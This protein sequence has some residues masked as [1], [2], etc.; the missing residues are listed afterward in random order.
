[1]KK[2][3]LY[4]LILLLLPFG[5]CKKWLTIEPKTETTQDKLF[6]SSQGYTDALT[7]IY[8]SMRT[9]YSP[10]SFMVSS[11][12]EFMSN[13]WY[14]VPDDFSVS[15][16]LAQ[17]NY[18][19]SSAESALGA[20]F[21]AQYNT[22]ANVN[23]LLTSLSTENVLESRVKKLVEGEALALRAFISFDLIR[24][25]GPMPQNP[26]ARLYL[27]YVKE[28][29]KN[30]YPYDNYQSYM[31]KLSA[32]LDKAEMLLQQVDPI[33]R[34]S[35]SALN[36]TYASIPEYTDLFWYMRQNK[37]NYYA[38]LGLQAR[39][40]LWMGDKA[41]AMRY[42]KMV[43]DANASGM[44][45]FT[46]GKASD[47]NSNNNAFFTEHLFGL[48]IEDYNDNLNSSG[49]FA[50]LATPVN[51]ITNDLYAGDLSDIRF[52]QFYNIYSSTFGM[53]VATSKKFS[54]MAKSAFNNSPFSVPLIRLSEMYLIVMECAPL[55][56]A[57]TF[58]QTFRTAK[59]ASY[60][61]MTDATRANVLLTEYIK[62]FYGEG[63]AFFTYKRLGTINMFWADHTTGESQY[64]PPL[65]LGETTN[66]Q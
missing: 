62:E 38:V 32:D 55:D 58:Y 22:L 37:M 10:A 8:L 23:A 65:P 44:K 29:S 7:G 63:Q 18:T 15:Y 17:H 53:Q 27:P 30:A 50:S 34:Y 13:L 1:M 41:N 51:R 36:T 66:I 12:I 43:I 61:P 52:S 48:N 40:K 6:A 28:K 5:S 19:N 3:T 35:T 33:L 42:A 59:N 64:V 24:L 60:T 56:E 2:L 14:A 39:M 9:N 46:F 20:T 54:G 49:R 21:L 4:S 57:N 31:A 45:Q 11:G 25:W 16:P 26:G 47:L